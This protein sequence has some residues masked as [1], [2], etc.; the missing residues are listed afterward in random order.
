MLLIVHKVFTVQHYNQNTCIEEV[1]RNLHGKTTNE[2]LF[3]LHFM[4]LPSG[5]GF[6]HVCDQADNEVCFLLFP[7][8]LVLHGK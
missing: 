7:I 3:I 1:S 6:G 4:R 2:I 8:I 5:T